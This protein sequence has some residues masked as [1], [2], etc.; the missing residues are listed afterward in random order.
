MSSAE[1]VTI[2]SKTPTTTVA[3]LCTRWRA[4]IAEWKAYQEAHPDEV[5]RF[6]RDGSPD[7]DRLYEAWNR[8]A[9]TILEGSSR[10]GAD[11]LAK[12]TLAGEWIQHDQASPADAEALIAAAREEVQRLLIPGAT[13]SSAHMSGQEILP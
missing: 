3:E 6:N 2:T 4:E 12:L 5:P 10:T 13:S 7:D 1:C 11:I 8:T 9:Q